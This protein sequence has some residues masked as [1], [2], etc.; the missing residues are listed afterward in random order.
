MGDLDLVRD[1]LVRVD[2]PRATLGGGHRPLVDRVLVRVRQRDHLRRPGELRHLERSDEVGD[3]EDLDERVLEPRLEPP[4]RPGGDGFREP[5]DAGADRVDLAAADRRHEV[6][7]E[8]LQTEPTFDGIL[9]PRAHEL[10]RV[11][12]PEVVGQ[13]QQ[14]DV[15]HVALDPLAQVEQAPELPGPRRNLDLEEPLEPVDRTH[16]IGDRTDAADPRNDVGDLA[17][18]AAPQEGLEEARRLVDLQLEPGDHV[19]VDADV[20]RAF[21]LHARDDRYVDRSVG[22]RSAASRS[23]RSAAS[24]KAGA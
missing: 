3:L 2:A 17:E 5:A 9:E 19:V 24:R 12:V 11:V 7:P 10:D 6:V 23:T 22:H 8:P 13:G 4:Q 16:L 15:Q 18:V 14:V 1:V 20:Q 21:A